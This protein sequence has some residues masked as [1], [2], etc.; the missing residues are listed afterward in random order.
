MVTGTYA[1]VKTPRWPGA[2]FQQ[3]LRM[4]RVVRGDRELHEVVRKS[5][6]VDGAH[7]HTGSGQLRADHRQFPGAIL[8]QNAHDFA[9]F[10]AN[11]CRIERVAGCF[12]VVGDEP[13]DDVIADRQ[14]HDGLEVDAVMT[15][16]GGNARQLAWAMRELN[17][18]ISHGSSCRSDVPVLMTARCRATDE[19]I[20]M[21]TSLA[22]FRRPLSFVQTQPGVP[23]R[24]ICISETVTLPL[25]AGREEL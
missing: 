8:E 11:A 23:V 3:P 25:I 4:T 18:E 22:C 5:R 9:F 17:G 12:D 13:N 10:E 7:V 15:E 20:P 6:E 1:T 2:S 19:P 21:S 14:A 24:R 16:H